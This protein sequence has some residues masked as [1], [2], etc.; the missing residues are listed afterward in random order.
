M[1]W[2]VE[3]ELVRIKFYADDITVCQTLSL[4]Q[5]TTPPVQDLSISALPLTLNISTTGM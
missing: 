1:L 4:G 3:K 5:T 2:K